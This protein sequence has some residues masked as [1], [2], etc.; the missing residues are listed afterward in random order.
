MD[1][2]YTAQVDKTRVWDVKPLRSLKPIFPPTNEAAPFV[3]T[4]PTGPFPTN[5]SPFYPIHISQPQHLHAAD[6]S[7]IRALPTPVPS[8]QQCSNGKKK[9][10]S[11]KRK[12]T[13]KRMNPDGYVIPM[14]SFQQDIGNEEMVKYILTTFDALRRR[15]SQ[16][17]DAKEASSGVIKRPDLKV[18][19]LLMNQGVRTNMRKLIG[20]V[21]GVGIGDIFYFRMEMCMVGLHAQSMGGIDYLLSTRSDEEEEEEPIAISIVSSGY[22]DDDA[23]DKD[24]LIY[25]GQGGAPSRGKEAS[26]QKLE[27][28]NLALDRSMHRGNEIRVIR[29]MSD[30]VNPIAKVYV[31]DGLYIIQQSWMEK[32]KKSG[33]NTFKYKLVR[34]P[35]Q[36]EVFS[37]WKSIQ[38]WKEDISSRPGVLLQNIASGTAESIPVSVFNDVDGEKGPPHFYYL[39]TLKYNKSFQLVHSSNECTCSSGCKPGNLNCSCIRKN[40]GDLPYTTNGIL[41]SRKSLIYE[42]GSTC[43]CGSNCKNRI[44]QRGPRVRLEVFKTLNKGWGLRTL[45]PI[46]AGSF[47]CEYAGE[48]LD[49]DSLRRKGGNDEYIFDTTRVYEKF[50]WNYEPELMVDGD[51]SES[52]ELNILSPSPLIITANEHGNV[53]RFMNHGCHPN[54]FWQ[55]IAY[56]NVTESYVHIGFFAM[57]HISPMTEL[58]YDYGVVAGDGGGRKAHAAAQRRRK[59]LCGY[60]KC[61]GFFGV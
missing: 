38:K 19:S 23:E 54:V 18:G 42:C 46:R 50:K 30:A 3:C 4:S 41:V 8:T 33:T 15:Y 35:G 44:S 59:C 45:D 17:E 7:P 25:S 60:S 21:P 53:A 56:G 24:V 55:P 2:V 39:A 13:F 27:R 32:D 1:N 49:E 22:Y 31:Y 6:P 61:R 10:K 51:S 5:Y 48:V 52:E 26:D 58:T 36:P 29:G 47:V 57:R 11:G 28:G 20:P 37:V 34:V 43:P 40:G 12:R 9:S 16:L 14:A